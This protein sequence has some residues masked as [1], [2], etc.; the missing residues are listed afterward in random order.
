MAQDQ[1]TK[2]KRGRQPEPTSFETALDELESITRRMESGD[3][4]LEESLEL[5][6]RGNFL[7]EFCRKR[8]EAAE[9]QIEELSITPGREVKTKPYDQAG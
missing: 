1:D 9:Q 7:V 5:Y 2:R 4:P 6:E 3:V 8:L